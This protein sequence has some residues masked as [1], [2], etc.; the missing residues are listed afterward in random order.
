M[1][2][3]IHRQAADN[4]I[5]QLS[6]AVREGGYLEHGR[7][8]ESVVV[9]RDKVDRDAVMQADQVLVG[10]NKTRL[11]YNDRLRE[12]RGLPFHE[13]VVG[14]RMVCLRNNPRKR[15]LNGQIWI[16]TDTTRRSNGKWSLMLADDEGKGET[17][18]LTHKAFF[19]GEEDAMSWPERRQFDEFTFGYC[20]TVHKAQGSQWDNVYLFDESFV[21]REERARWLYTGI[22]RAAEKITVVS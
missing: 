11:T 10:R 3:E 6:M 8:G 18:V 12:L 20:L 16:V 14:D 2:T 5:I 4:P 7:Y 17:R 1:L 9:G 19:S 21:F 13:P 22:T 15:L